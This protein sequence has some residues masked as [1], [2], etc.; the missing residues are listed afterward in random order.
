MSKMTLHEPFGHL[1]PGYG[2][3]KGRESKLNWQF[4]SW[5]LKVRNRPD[6]DVFRRSA[7]WRWKA[8]KESYKISS[9][10]IPIRGLSKKLWMPKVSRVQPGTVSGL[11]LGSPRKKC[12]SDV[13]PW[14]VVENTIWGKVVA[15]PESGPW[16]IKWVQGRPWL[17]PTPK[18]CKMSSNQLV[19]SFGCRT[20]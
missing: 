13:A 6:C 10:F 19:V 8:L 11:F 2:Q 4:D 20:E 5:P 15:S 18:G 14:G 12:H 16:W 3:K 1:S 17:V 9:N 7:T